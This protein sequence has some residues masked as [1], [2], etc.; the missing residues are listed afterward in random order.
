MPNPYVDGGYAVVTAV[1][2][3][4]AAILAARSRRVRHI[5]I[6]VPVRSAK[7]GDGSEDLD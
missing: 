6:E 7:R 5:P 1:L 2:G 4:Y 3:G